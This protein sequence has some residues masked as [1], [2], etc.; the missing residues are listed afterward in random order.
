[1]LFKKDKKS[2]KATLFKSEPSLPELNSISDTKKFWKQS[3]RNYENSM[4]LLMF[5]SEEEP[6]ELSQ[7]Y[8]STYVPRDT[9][10][11][12]ITDPDR[13]NPTRSRTERPLQT[14]MGFEEAIYNNTFGNHKN[15][16][17]YMQSNNIYDTPRYR[18]STSRNCTSRYSSISYDDMYH[19]KTDHDQSP[20]IEMDNI[21]RR[22]KNSDGYSQYQDSYDGF[23][24]STSSSSY[25]NN[26]DNSSESN[27]H[28]NGEYYPFSNAHQSTHL[29]NRYKSLYDEY[30]QY[31][32]FYPVSSD[33]LINTKTYI[34]PK[35]EVQRFFST[36]TGFKNK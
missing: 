19:L 17:P 16:N 5:A 24:S 15:N 4:K 34:S 18:N 21:N 3:Y 33:D 28:S 23:H 13:S 14:I 9:K 10:G 11:Y 36:K 31:D 27:Y 29:S 1:M 32:G 30:N 25:I 2:T 7:R 35:N 8:F 12:L 26:Y 20:S 22:F 6:W